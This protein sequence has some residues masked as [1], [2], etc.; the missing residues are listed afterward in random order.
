[1][2]VIN[3]T[4]I[5]VAMHP[6]N[7]A[8]P[9]AYGNPYLCGNAGGIS[10]TYAGGAVLG[11][12]SWNFVL[13]T[14]NG[15]PVYG[16][17]WVENLGGTG[18]G[19]AC[20]SGGTNNCTQYGLSCGLQRASIQT[21]S[22]STICGT[23]LGQW[24]VDEMCTLNSSFSQA[25]IFDC[26]APEGVATNSQ[27]ATCSAPT[28]TCY[29]QTGKNAICCGCTNWYDQTWNGQ[30]I[31]VPGTPY[32]KNCAYPNSN[33]LTG[34]SGSGGVLP[35]LLWLKA[36]CP[37]CYVYSFDDVSSTFGCPSNNGQSAVN[38]TVEFCPNALAPA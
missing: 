2:T 38:Y 33:W 30:T 32:V 19:T 26:T 28:V 36:A 23:L 12:A 7:A 6:T 8:S 31:Q 37:S 21:N 34:A 16:F 14:Q 13:P 18:A 35:N 10:N 24:T 4:N 15:A 29:T 25:S 17:N 5:P 22:A 3:G 11:G 9:S 1:M 20:P 27:L